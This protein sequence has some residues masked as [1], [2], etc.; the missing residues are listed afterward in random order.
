[1]PDASQASASADATLQPNRAAR[2]QKPNQLASELHSLREE[3]SALRASQAERVRIEAELTGARQ[4]FQY[5]LSVSP[6]IIYTTQASGDFACTFVSD[7]IQAIMGFA[8]EEMTTDAKCW[9]ARLHPDDASRV[10][11]ELP[12]LIQQGGGAV[13]YRFRH[14]DGHYVWIQDTFKVI[15]DAAGHPQELVGAWA[16]ISDRKEAEQG[17]LVANHELQETKRYL[18][19]LIESSPDAIISTDQHGKVV[20]FNEGAEALLGYRT[21][22][23]TGRRAAMLYGG[24]AGANEVLREMRKRGGTISG[25]NT[26][27]QAKDGGNIPVLISAS[28]LFDEENQEIGTVGFATDLRETKRSQEALQ[29]AYD[30][31]ERRV[32]NRTKELQEA[33]ARLQYLLTVTP[34]ILYTTQVSGGYACTFVSRNVESIMGFS[35]WEM[36]EDPEFWSNRVHP[37]DA[38]RLFEEMGSLITKG[39]GAFEYRFR[40]RDGNYVWIQDTFKVVHDE[41]GQPLELVGSWADITHRKQVEHALGERMALM[42]DLQNLVAASPAVIY[43]TNASGGFAC[44]FVSENLLPTMGYA[45]WEMRDDPKFWSKRLHPDDASR[46]FSEMDPMIDRGGGAM[47]YRFRHRRGDYIWIQDTFTTIRDK[48]GNPKELVGSWADISDRKKIEGELQRVAE[49]L[50]RRNRFIRDTFGRYLTDE[51]VETLLESPSRLQVGGDKRQVTMMMTD[52]RGFTSLSE[53]LTPKWVVALL[54]RYLAAMVDV[55]KRYDG[56]I[57]KFIGDAIFVLFGAPIWKEDDAQRAVACAVE[58]QLAMAAVN[59]QNRSDGLP[60]LEMGIGINTGQVVVGNIGS[61]ERMMYGVVGGHVNLV[62]RIQSCTVGGQILISEGTRR[63]VGPMLRIGR[64]VEVRAKGFEQPL[65]LSEVVGIG[66]PYKLSLM[67]SRDALA[68]IAEEIPIEC[69]IIERSRLSQE[70]FKARVTKLSMKRAVA[71]FQAD[72]PVLSDLEIR[73]DIQ[74]GQRVP[75][76]LYGKVTE[77]VH[78]S[79]FE[80]LIYFTSMSEEIKMALS[81]L[82]ETPG[83]LRPI[84]RATLGTQPS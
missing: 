64:Q 8:P 52:L 27:L 45:P 40:H 6:A 46:V 79:G 13:A 23:V 1:M 83:K 3:N 25:F 50:E 76:A 68:A 20:L 59:E 55:I 19:R 78:D 56:T 24:D 70:V 47:E 63:E 48:E 36:I 49:E 42:N 28:V 75:G 69:T 74:D 73:I 10:F 65:T 12:P 14:R 26:V 18:S 84:R 67:Q 32:E 15:Y 30:D 2:R 80:F 37:D 66:G 17:A 39:G 34:G 16:D 5:L 77:V 21:D 22:E 72:I 61:P 71:R 4:R 7:N 81:Q 9:P 38:Q 58:M 62:S 29:K 33:R 43:T 53:R 82:L 57:D 44:T 35:E 51:I 54:N 11:E 31:L 41:Q 60:D